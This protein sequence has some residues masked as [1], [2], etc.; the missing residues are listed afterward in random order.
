MPRL[1]FNPFSGTFDY[2]TR[3]G[4]GQVVGEQPTGPIDGINTSFLTAKKF[5]QGTTRVHLNGQRLREGALNDYVVLESGGF[6]SGF[7][8]IVLAI[9]PVPTP[10]PDVIIVDYTER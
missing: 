1:V 10:Q 9:P 8:T 5:I 6:G 7:D 2:V 4:E 3:P